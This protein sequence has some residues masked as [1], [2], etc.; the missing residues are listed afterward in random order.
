MFEDSCQTSCLLSTQVSTGIFHTQNNGE[1]TAI[2]WLWARKFVFKGKKQQQQQTN[3]HWRSFKVHYY[4]EI[5]V[6]HWLPPLHYIINMTI[7]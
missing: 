3:S 6:I 5:T 1:G 4:E 7:S 2:E